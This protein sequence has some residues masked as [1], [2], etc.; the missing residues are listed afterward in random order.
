V[1]DD[2]TLEQI[3]SNDADDAKAAF[4][5]ELDFFEFELALLVAD[6]LRKRAIAE[7]EKQEN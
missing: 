3:L 1:N 7:P 2:R 6:M 5:A 4:D